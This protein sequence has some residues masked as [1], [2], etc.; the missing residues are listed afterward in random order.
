MFTDSL[1]GSLASIG[2]SLCWVL[3]ALSF[4]AAGRQVGSAIVNTSRLIMAVIILFLIHRAVLDSWWPQM[5]WESMAWLAAS[6]IIGL[7]IGDQLCFQALVD[8]GSRITTLLLTLAP[9]ITA[10]M[11]WP[12]LDE[13]LGIVSVLGMTV[14]LT[15]IA[16]VVSE[17]RESKEQDTDGSERHPRRGILFAS[18]AG[19]AQALG[20]ILAKLGMGD[21]DAMDPWSA[22]LMRLIFGTGTAILLLAIIRWSARRGATPVRQQG[23]LTV[24]WL[25]IVVG[26]IF[27]PV[28]GVWLSL[29]GIDRIEAGIAATLMSLSPVFI[30]PFAA[31]FEKDR[32]TRRAILGALVSVIGVAI[33][34]YGL[35][36]Q[37]DRDIAESTAPAQASSTSFEPGCMS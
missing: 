26:A 34:A 13:T 25:L 11:A 20:L 2:A 37:G 28:L 14:T 35:S 6:G 16:W 36:R 12:I 8:V 19:I 24:A 7:G 29:V 23:R 1:I 3:T 15:G 4:A 5:S 31:W 9:P 30:I 27:G 32:V 33:L 10:I 18:G 21:H 17:G 22:T